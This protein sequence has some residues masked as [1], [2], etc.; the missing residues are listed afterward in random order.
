MDQCPKILRSRKPRILV[1]QGQVGAKEEI[2]NRI[3]VENPVNQK[4]LRVPLEVNPIVLRSIP[5]QHTSL[6][7]HTAKSLFVQ[8]IKLRRQEMKL[9]KQ[10]QLKVLRQCRHLRCTDLVKNYLKHGP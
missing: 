1:I 6:P 9:G 8:M 4:P 10:L 3:L 2:S 7:R 5:M